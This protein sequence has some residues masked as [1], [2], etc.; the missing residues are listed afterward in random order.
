[1]TTPSSHR[2]FRSWI[3][4]LIVPLLAIL[5]WFGMRSA[6]V[7]I[8]VS[9][10]VRGTLEVTVNEDGETR[11]REPYL[12]SAPLAGRL[13]RVEWEPGDLIA[14]GQI[15]A[16]IDPGEPGLLDIR[17]QAEFE[18]RVKAA[19]ASHRRALSQLEIAKAEEDKAERYFER[20]QRRL[21][22]GE[23][24]APMLA[25]S[26]TQLRV[27]RSNVSAANSV[28]EI[29]LFEL[30]QAKAALL[31]SRNLEEGS[32]SGDLG[33]QFEIKSPIDGVVLRKFHESSTILPAADRILEIGDP[34]DLEIRID[35]LSEDAVKIRPGDPVR[36]EHW[37]GNQVLEAHIRRVEPSAFTK[38]SALG[39]DEQRV[40]V[41][42]DFA[43]LGPTDETVSSPEN[44]AGH[45][46]LGDGY[47]VEA[48]IVV[49][50]EENVLKVPSG[51]LFRNP[52]TREWSVF[53]AVD[54]KA[55]LT[56]I[57]IGRDNGLEAEVLDGLDE[58]DLIVLHPGDRVK[59]GARVRVRAQ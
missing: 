24:A 36:L 17:T 54:G 50:R 57:S 31:H 9:E 45:S 59:E 23:I 56:E 16:A 49:W 34:E 13:V 37:G 52:E 1:M 25:D 40:W 58:G 19:G 27:A 42:A 12:I 33:R 26:E 29:A 44:E 48:S 4:W 43:S 22:T 32:N 38:V 5:I 28:L 30:E 10:T 3:K 7:E 8:D 47:R 14:A 46:L 2:K 15:I 39:V 20:D 6:P 35:V 53:R 55:Q 18:A 21:A 41:Y 51:G 11:I